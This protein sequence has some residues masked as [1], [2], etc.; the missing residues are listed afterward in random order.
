MNG[1]VKEKKAIQATGTTINENA[2][3]KQRETRKA[4]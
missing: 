1:E 3:W 4:R 2:K